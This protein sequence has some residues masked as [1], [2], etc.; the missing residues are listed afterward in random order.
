LDNLTLLGIAIII[1]WL[2]LFGYYF[3]TSRQQGEVIEE[4]EELKKMLEGT[5]S[6]DE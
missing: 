3:V 4:V 6:E 5:N 1:I 2:L